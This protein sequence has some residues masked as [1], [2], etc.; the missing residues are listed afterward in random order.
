MET[1]CED[2]GDVG[3]P[4][5][6]AA[7]SLKPQRVEN[8]SRG[9]VAALRCSAAAHSGH[10]H[11]K[12]QNLKVRR[13]TDNKSEYGEY[14]RKAP[15]GCLRHTAEIRGVRCKKQRKSMQIT[16]RQHGGLHYFVLLGST[17]TA[18]LSNCLKRLSVLACRCFW[19]TSSVTEM[20]DW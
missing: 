13:A 5:L 2:S 17:S 15:S 7:Q 9:I 20:I 11:P 18:L 4:Q 10:P 12:Y 8:G 16:G 19:L 3:L 1:F 6:G 14:S